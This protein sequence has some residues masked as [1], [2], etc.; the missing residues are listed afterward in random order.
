MDGRRVALLCSALCLTT[1]C[2]EPGG[3]AGP[4]MAAE[5]P[6]ELIHA[7]VRFPG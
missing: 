7:L 4:P 3:G 2:A 5:D 1:S 6:D